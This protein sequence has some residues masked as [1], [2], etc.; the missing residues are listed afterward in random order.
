MRSRPSADIFL[1][2]PACGRT[3]ERHVAFGKFGGRVVYGAG[4]QLDIGADGI[5]ELG[6]GLLVTSV[7]RELAD[8][9]T[10]HKIRA[11]QRGHEL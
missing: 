10:D 5:A 6:D 3:S 4:L 7:V 11:L 8:A 2:R 1:P 9:S